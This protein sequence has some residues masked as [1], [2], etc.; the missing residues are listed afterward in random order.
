MND[1]QKDLLSIIETIGTETER[2]FQDVQEMA[3]I[4]VEEIAEVVEFIT[5]EVETDLENFWQFLFEPIADLNDSE[6]EDP[7]EIIEEM[8]EYPDLS[9]NPKIEPTLDNHPACV[10]CLNYHGR[11]YNGVLLVCG[12]HPYGWMDEN[13]PDW[14]ND[15]K[16]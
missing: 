14:E 13:C 1:W 4:V 15:L 6:M 10:N 3:E 11:I 9:L 2:F 8:V 12:M 7:E 5:E 16:G